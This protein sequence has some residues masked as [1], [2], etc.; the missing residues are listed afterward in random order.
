[1]P[2]IQTVRTDTTRF[3]PSNSL[4]SPLTPKK[5]KKRKYLQKKLSRR[6]VSAPGSLPTCIGWGSLKQQRM[7]WQVAVIAL[8]APFSFLLF[9]LNILWWEVK[10]RFA[11]ILWF[12]V[13]SFWPY[14]GRGHLSQN[15]K[16]LLLLL[17]HS[18][19][20]GHTSA[21][22]SLQ[23]GSRLGG[24]GLLWR[25]HRNWLQLAPPDEFWFK[26]QL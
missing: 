22:S 26:L 23:Q 21:P 20:V 24:R 7:G 16:N 18:A 3:S 12:F 14:K 2:L 11:L 9:Q 4:I 19:A 1:M 5:A 25:F 10:M 13:K 15:G 17:Y 6:Q 8:Q